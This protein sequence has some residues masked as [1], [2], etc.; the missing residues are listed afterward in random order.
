MEP[1]ADATPLEQAVRAGTEAGSGRPE[2]EAGELDRARPSRHKAE[3]A[4]PKPKPRAEGRCKPDRR[5]RQGGRADQAGT[6]QGFRAR[7]QARRGLT[8]WPPTRA[9]RSRSP[10]SS[11]SACSRSAPPCRAASWCW[12]WRRSARCSARQK[13]TLT[14]NGHTDGGRSRAKPTTTGGC[15]RRA[16]IRPTTCWCAPASTSTASP[17][18]PASPTAS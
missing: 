18:S 5:N 16:P 4:R 1:P 15:P 6:R 8:S 13:G 14:I 3:P 9:S 10:T 2:A 11:T 17:R 7:R 12:R